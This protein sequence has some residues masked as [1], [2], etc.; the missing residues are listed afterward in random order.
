MCAILLYF[1]IKTLILSK[2]KRRGFSPSARTFQTMFTG[3]SKIE[4]WSSHTKQ[5][6]N[7]RLLYDSFQRYMKSVKKHDPKSPELTAKPL[8]NYIKILGD[9]EL[10]QDIFDVY[11][12]LP[13]D[14]QGSAEEFVY[15]AMF[16]ALASTPTGISATPI[17]H[18]NATNAKALWNMMN[19]ALKQSS[20]FSVDAH[21]ASA[22]IA[23][24][25]RGQAP[26]VDLAFAIASEYFGLT[27]QGD[28]PSNGTIPLST[29]S[30]D[31][32]FKLC[33]ASGKH[34][35]CLTFFQQVKRRSGGKEIL[36]Y[37][38]L[39][40]VLKA[41]LALPGPETASSC[42]GIIE[43]MLKNEILGKN[44]SKLRPNLTSY[45]LAMTACWRDADWRHAT[46]LFDLMTGYH[47]HDFM[48]GSVTSEPRRDARSLRRNLDPPPETL[49]SLVRTARASRNRANVRQSLRIIDHL[50]V[51]TLFFVDDAEVGKEKAKFYFTNKLATAI[52][53]AVNFASETESKAPPRHQEMTRWKRIADAAAQYEKR[54]AAEKSDFIPTMVK[55]WPEKGE[56]N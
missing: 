47:S 42:L 23:A 13:T 34:A 31:A 51:K 8:A 4:N 38:H 15:T 22:A 55:H 32:I 9:N 45:N 6:G 41:H 16:Q 7:A 20:S 18:Q 30:L 36:D 48:D 44:G 46:R 5:L 52:V 39:N 28:P 33:N 21:L 11:H 37:G 40:E 1:Y 25:S 50:K 26:E 10:Y 2:M 29:Q 53:D 12:A 49:Y 54:M 27:A 14:G 3:L 17:H 35:L 24:L 56:A 19:K 43:W